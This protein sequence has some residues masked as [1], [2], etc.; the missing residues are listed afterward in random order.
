[1]SA[2]SKTENWQKPKIEIDEYFKYKKYVLKTEF[3]LL[4]YYYN[5]NERN[6][7][8]SVQ[9]SNI[10]NPEF[11]TRTTMYF[12]HTFLLLSLRL[13][14]RNQPSHQTVAGDHGLRGRLEQTITFTP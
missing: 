10:N 11:N 3:T 4:H 14:N 8:V 5:R 6:H 13:V 9:S 1:M 7:T 2:K 12:S